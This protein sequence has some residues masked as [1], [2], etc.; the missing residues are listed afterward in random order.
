MKK[1]NDLAVRAAAMAGAA[2]IGS[3][4]LTGCGNRTPDSSET[5]EVSG[6]SGSRE[7]L[8]EKLFEFLP[9]DNQNE[10]VYGPPPENRTGEDSAADPNDDYD[11]SE[12]I[13]EVVYGPPPEPAD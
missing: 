4:V 10:D 5:G 13:P 8:L 12:N 6:Q 9:A 1:R 3:T 7:S 11:P 2:L